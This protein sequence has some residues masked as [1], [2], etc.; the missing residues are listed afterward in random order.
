MSPSY[1]LLLDEGNSEIFFMV[2]K[3]LVP[4]QDHYSLSSCMREDLSRNK[5][6]SGKE[7]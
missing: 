6:I 3:L 4:E 1:A 7:S 5:M 2:E